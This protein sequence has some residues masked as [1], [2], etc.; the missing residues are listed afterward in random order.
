MSFER[1]EVPD[2]R[3]EKERIGPDARVFR[4]CK[5]TVTCAQHATAPNNLNKTNDRLLKAAKKNPNR[6]DV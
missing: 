2:S 4:A 5:L 3:P 6:K 1:G